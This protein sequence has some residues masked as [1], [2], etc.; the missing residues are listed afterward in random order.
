MISSESE[1]TSS[2]SESGSSWPFILSGTYFEVIESKPNDQNVVAKCIHCKEK[3]K[4][5]VTS[6]SNFTKHLKLRKA[7]IINNLH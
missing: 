6:S 3:V 4:G 7:C 2:R 1:D 5:H